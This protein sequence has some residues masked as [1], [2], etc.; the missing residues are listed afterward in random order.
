MVYTRF[1]ALYNDIGCLSHCAPFFLLYSVLFYSLMEVAVSQN[2]MLDFLDFS[3]IM[4]Q[5]FVCLQAFILVD[6]LSTAPALV[7]FD[8]LLPHIQFYCSVK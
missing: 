8:L 3:S 2:S 4:L 7:Y 6:T 5:D 1:Y